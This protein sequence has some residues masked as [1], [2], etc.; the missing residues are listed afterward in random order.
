MIEIGTALD[1]QAI[2]WVASVA[3]VVQIAMWLLVFVAHVRAVVKKQ[4]LW[5]G[6]GKHISEFL[7]PISYQMLSRKTYSIRV[8]QPAPIPA[9]LFHQSRLLVFHD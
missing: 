4:I 8:Q 2:L 3:T 5:P 9:T 1:S 6:R 7:L